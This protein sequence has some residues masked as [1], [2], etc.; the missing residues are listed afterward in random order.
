MDNESMTGL[1]PFARTKDKLAIVGFSINSRSLAPY[2]SPDHEIWIM[3][4]EY[5]QPWVKRFDRLFQLHPKYDYMRRTNTN[6]ANHALWLTN[7]SDT[8]YRC[9]GTLKTK[10]FETGKEITCPECKLGIYYP[11][12]DRLK[13]PVYLQKDD[14]DVPGSFAYPLGDIMKDLFPFTDKPYFTSSPAFILAMGIWMGFRRIELYGLEMG[15]DTEYHYQRAN[16]EYLIGLA[17]GRGVEVVLINSQICSGQLYGYDNMKIGFRQDLEIRSEFLE[18]RIKETEKQ[19]YIASGRAALA[20]EIKEKGNWT[21]EEI[22]GLVKKETEEADKRL[23]ETNFKKGAA[24]ELDQMTK[25][26]DAYFRAENINEQLSQGDMQR[27]LTT[28]YAIE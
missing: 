6:D 15:T 8:C 17:R 9:K 26:F 22:E 28:D 10:D 23:A 12:E 3:N 1:P 13:Y 19:R 5:N 14:P 18:I 25:V 20:R 24:T 4:E 21:D 11:P 16:F 7:K 2:D 27:L